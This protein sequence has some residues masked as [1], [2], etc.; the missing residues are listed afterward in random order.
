MALPRWMLFIWRIRVGLE[1]YDCATPQGRV[2]LYIWWVL[3]GR[4]DYP[5][6]DWPLTEQDREYLYGLRQGAM[7]A[8][9]ERYI[10]NRPDLQ[11]IAH[12]NPGGTEH[13]LLWWLVHGQSEPF[14]EAT[15][16]DVLQGVEER[17]PESGVAGLLWGLRDDLRE[18][19]DLRLESGR[20]GLRRWWEQHAPREYPQLT[21]SL[22][23]IR[24][25]S[26][27]AARPTSHPEGAQDP[28]MHDEEGVNIVGFARGVL[29]IG[30]DARMAQRTVQHAGFPTHAVEP[31]LLWMPSTGEE[32]P[33]QDGPRVEKYGVS[34]FCLPPVEMI[35]LVLEG[36]AELFE[37]ATYKV[38]A[39]P[40]ELPRWPAEFAGVTR[41]VDEIW[42]QSSFVADTFG[43]LDGA[44][45]V[46]IH[47]VPLAVELAPPTARVRAR[48]VLP[49]RDYI[50]YLMFDGNS[51][52]SRK[53]PV[54]GVRAFQKAF[55]RQVR[56]VALVVKAM[57]IKPE[58]P[59]WREVLEAAAA[60]SRI[61][62]ITDTLPK[63]DLINL[64]AS[65][66][67]YISLHRS[68][69]FGRVI[70]EAMLLG[71][72]VVVTDYS[73]NVDFCDSTTAYL[74]DGEIVP[75]RAGD[76]VLPQG[77]HWCEPDPE[78]AAARLKE[79]V[80][81]VAGRA[82]IAG[83]GQRRIREEFSPEAVSRI[84][85]ERLAGIFSKLSVGS[86]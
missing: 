22:L 73:G 63:Q 18:A 14:I 15:A 33:R 13:L 26:A 83:A 11:R 25:R 35:R 54:A 53:N 17:F 71:Q 61:R 58:H 24:E 3:Y 56:G 78:Q 67:A 52:L 39:W 5:N 76:Y 32:Q 51:W 47:R 50:F 7:P 1:A 43:K 79:V 49:E 30:E 21:E 75:L 19:Y 10:A 38:G 59:L 27:R 82:R 84:Y 12:T 4:Q 16:A 48:H 57:N 2:D 60:D 31:R 23:R 80:D 41:L 68:E 66:D 74:V 40:W 34:I 70:A 65:C 6:M 86:Y 36:S 44:S 9:L 42:A 81:D 69:G 85:R 8:A 55:P 64:M 45:R 37:S 46:P 72:P 28:A 29:G 77:Q 20:E 62:I